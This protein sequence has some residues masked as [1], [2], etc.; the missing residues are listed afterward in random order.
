MTEEALGSVG[1][2]NPAPCKAGI[3]KVAGQTAPPVV[4][5][6]VTLVQARPVATGSCTTVLLAAPGPA[7]LTVRVYVVVVPLTT[8][9][10]AFDL[11]T[12]TLA[13]GCSVVVVGG[14]V[15]GGW[16]PAAGPSISVTAVLVIVPVALLLIVT[17]NSTVAVAPKAMTPAAWPLLLTAAAVA[18]SMT[19]PAKSATATPLSLV[20]PAT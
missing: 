20:L 4:P 15:T 9:L 2:T 6:Q 10:T 1:T 16:L 11:V 3:V 7:L 19:P 12:L 8:E 13:G 17:L 18:K 5:V 14:G